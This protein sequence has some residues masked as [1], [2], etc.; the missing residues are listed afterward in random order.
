VKAYTAIEKMDKK[1]VIYARVSTDEQAAK[2]YS[3]PTQLDACRKYA[4][5][6]GFTV[7]SEL[8]DDCSGA[9]P[10]RDRPEG[11][12]IYHLIEAGGINALILYTLDRTA[13]DEMGLE[14]LLLKRDLMARGIEL[15]YTDTGI[16]ND[17]MW[18]NAIGYFKS[19]G[20]ADE[21]RKI[22]ERTT[23]GKNAKARNNDLV[24][25]GHPPFGY[26]R[27]GKSKEA[28]LVIDDEEAG[29][30]KSIFEWYTI[31][32]GI[33]GPL[34]LRAIA[35]KLEEGG[36]PT[37]N[38]RTNAAD[39]WIPATIRGILK[40]EI[41]TGHTYYGKSRV[42]KKKRIKQPQ[43]EWI[44]IDVPQLAIIERDI[45]ELAQKR[46]K[47]NKELAARNKKNDYLLSGFF[48]CGAC[49]GAM[50]G[51]IAGAGKYI[52]R[53]Y[54]CGTHWH[55]P[56][57]PHCP[58]ED[59]SVIAHKAEDT[60]WNWL[61]GLLE[62]EERLDKGL[63]EMEVRKTADIEPK[64]K[65]LETIAGLVDK[66]ERNIKR[67]AR[68]SAEEENEFI[69][70]TLKNEMKLA[71]RQRDDLLAE[72]QR[73]ESDISQKVITPVT[74]ERILSSAA[75]I[76]RKLVNP[77]YRQKRELLDMLDLTV[78]FRVDEAGRWLDVSCGL[79]PDGDVI[80]LDHSSVSSRLRRASPSRDGR[81]NWPECR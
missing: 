23:R 63:R 43:E 42:V 81:S 41:Y 27:V 15:H 53:N 4:A 77:T 1:A 49:G 18:S 47:R 25:T 26:K 79:K 12:K 78:I 34:S 33:G 54:R 51:T 38:H 66:L 71:G 32:D 75:T 67:L 35:F 60:V 58:N 64:L 39:Y 24:M 59:R 50:T 57:R 44:A 29:I 61:T 45:F 72:R 65:R 5:R 22:I 8:A 3:L 37:P 62:D 17:D 56:D 69:A 46:L 9:I 2:G 36:M 52:Y 19:L 30:V 10:I 74:R 16:D 7:I 76:R 55:K 14:Y 28:H 80:V 70:E 40:N 73:L 21:R 68:D 20:A 13:R 11:G 31:G 48:R 6:L